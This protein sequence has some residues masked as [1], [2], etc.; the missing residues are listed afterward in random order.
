MELTLTPNPLHDQRQT[1][2]INKVA[3]LVGENGSGKSSILQ[4]V[5]EDRLNKNA[6]QHLN[7]VCFSSGQNESYSEKFRAYLKR[8]RQAGRGLGLECFFLLV[9]T[10]EGA[11]S[12]YL[13]RARFTRCHWLL[14]G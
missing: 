9:L 5:F 13:V 12:T 8:E 14:K 6:H 10:K 11:I 4:S 1:L 3:T 2:H 7:V